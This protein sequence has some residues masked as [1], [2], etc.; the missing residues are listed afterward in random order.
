MQ[1]VETTGK[2]IEEAKG[3]ALDQLG[4]AEDDAEFE[5]LVE[6][7]SSLFG[8]R[9]GEARVRARVKPT[10]VRPKLENRDRRK[11]REGAKAAKQARPSGGNSAKPGRVAAAAGQAVAAAV[12]APRGEARRSENQHGETQQSDTKQAPARKQQPKR[13]K[14]PQTDEQSVTAQPVREEAIVSAQQVGEEA[15][16]FMTEL[17][18]AFGLSGSVSLIED[19]DDL[20]VRVSG[21]DLGLMVGPRGKHVAGDSGPGPGGSP[22]PSRGSRHAAARRRWWVS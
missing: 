12:D 5:I 17:V 19:G 15:T 6:P 16:K 2:T 18:S 20:E 8:L 13:E 7:R 21:E 10:T 14:T 22:T 9:K 11:A 1:W 3:L 4:V